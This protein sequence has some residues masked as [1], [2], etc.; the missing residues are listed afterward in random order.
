MSIAADKG[1][2]FGSSRLAVD[3]ELLLDPVYLV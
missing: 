2:Q 3:K 1:D